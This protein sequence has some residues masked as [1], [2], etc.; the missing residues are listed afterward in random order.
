MA[1]TIRILPSAQRQL[2]RL[3]P[4]LQKVLAAAIDALAE[5]PRPPGVK[6]LSGKENLWRTRVADYRILYQILDKQLLILVVA[7][8]HRRDIYR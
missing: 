2:A 8:G 1:Y 7:M 4:P 3:D 5:H 6:K